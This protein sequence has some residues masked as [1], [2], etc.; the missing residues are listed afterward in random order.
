MKTSTGI[1]VFC[2]AAGP[3][4]LPQRSGGQQ[5][6]LVRGSTPG[7]L[8]NEAYLEDAYAAAA[9]LYDR[10]PLVTRAGVETQI[11]E[12]VGRKPGAQLRFEDMVD[13]SIVR[14]LDKNGFIDKV[15]TK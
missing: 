5:R 14:E 1:L 13:D 7:F 8:N 12:A 11:K 9:K 2:R 15:Y 10:V 3:F 4:L 6:C